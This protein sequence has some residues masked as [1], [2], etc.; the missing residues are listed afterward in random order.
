LLQLLGR[1]LHERE[2]GMCDAM[3]WCP[4]C[5]AARRGGFSRAH[6]RGWNGLPGRLTRRLRGGRYPSLS[7]P[8]SGHLGRRS[9]RSRARN[10]GIVRKSSQV[11]TTPS[12][13]RGDHPSGFSRCRQRAAE[14]AM[15]SLRAHKHPPRNPCSV[16][17]VGGDYIRHACFGAGG[18]MRGWLYTRPIGYER[19]LT[20][21]VGD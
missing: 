10:G 5:G 16:G 2:H 6:V 19:T 18:C 8:R 9:T 4:R 11:I 3:L 20:W 12:P 1:L 17:G 14:C 7:H 13:R 15:P 21:L